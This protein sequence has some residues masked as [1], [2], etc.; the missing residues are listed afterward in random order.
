MNVTLQDLA[1]LAAEAGLRSPAIVVE[2][3]DDGQPA[4]HLD[5][6]A[7]IYPASMIKLPIAMV[8]ASLVEARAFAWTDDATVTARNVT[9]N[10]A[11]SPFVL[12]CTA[13]LGAYARAM[14]AA[15][16]NVATNVLIDVLGRETISAACASFGLR[17]TVVHRKLSGALPL[18]DDP[19]ATGRNRHPADDAAMLF[20]TLARDRA[21][22]A[23]HSVVYDALEAQIWN[24]KL[25]RGLRPGD[26]F[27][28][29]TGD[30][31]EVSHDGGI[32]T[33]PSGRRFIIVVYTPM[34][35]DPSTDACH[36]AFMHA[37]RPHLGT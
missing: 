22:G 32:L 13:E 14:L 15:S 24:D 23:R 21:R 18:I 19:E 11:P 5:A 10:D 2:P 3:L 25:S 29:K 9:V 37:L 31:D 28:H 1:E 6:T 27:A 26:H 16:D 7:E 33:L 17:D 4:L 35:S 8:Y 12:G 30:T 34:P 20:R 36:A